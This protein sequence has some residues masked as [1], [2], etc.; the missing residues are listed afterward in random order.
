[1]IYI[2]IY[3]KYNTTINIACKGVL[4]LGIRIDYRGVATCMQTAAAALLCSAVSVL[5]SSSHCMK[6]MYGRGKNNISLIILNDITSEEM[7]SIL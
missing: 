3:Y 4:Y 5:S 6:K 2:Y 1:M 7:L